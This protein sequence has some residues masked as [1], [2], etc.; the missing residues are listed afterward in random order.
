M[1]Q[2]KGHSRRKQ[3]VQGGVALAGKRRA[4]NANRRVLGESYLNRPSATRKDH[5][6]K[7][8]LDAYPWSRAIQ[9]GGTAQCRRKAAS[10]EKFRTGKASKTK[11]VEKGHTG[12]REDHR[13]GYWGSGGGNEKG[14]KV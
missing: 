10:G 8:A 12:I 6:D 14:K 7:K 5:R 9:G 13:E 1:P 3:A 11:H 4:G 2:K